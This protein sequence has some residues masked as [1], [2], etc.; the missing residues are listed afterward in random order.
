MKTIQFLVSTQYLQFPPYP[1]L[2]FHEYR[3]QL[4][5][6]IPANQGFPKDQAQSGKTKWIKIRFEEDWDQE[7]ERVGIWYGQ[8][9]LV[10]SIEKKSAIKDCDS[11]QF[12]FS[13]PDLQ[14]WKSV[15]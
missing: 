9:K 13:V 3:F 1:G 14:A 7:G 11:D 5:L 10:E 8:D 4:G 2:I 6:V 15:N 12:L